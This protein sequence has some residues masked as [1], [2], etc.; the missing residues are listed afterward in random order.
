M[1]TPNRRVFSLFPNRAPKPI[2]SM[3]WLTMDVIRWSARMVGQFWLCDCCKCV[4]IKTWLFVGGRQTVSL[5]SG[6]V[7]KGIIMHELMHAVGFFHE[8]S[9]TDRDNYVDILYD[10]IKT[11]MSGKLLFL[12][13]LLLFPL[14]ILQVSSASTALIVS[15]HWAPI[16]ITVRVNCFT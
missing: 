3:F 10:N 2:M 1:S 12:L 4:V 15:P 8:Q 5:G 13:L 14:R 16:M 11:G 6:C 7:Q 9:R